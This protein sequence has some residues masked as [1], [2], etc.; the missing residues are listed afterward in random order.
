M[1][2]M[3][4]SHWLTP[5]P[6]PG[7]R[8][9]WVVCDYTEQFTL[10]RDR[11]P[12]VFYGVDHGPSAGSGPGVMARSHCMEPGPGPGQGTGLTQ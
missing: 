7:T 5:G 6:E 12:I 11:D 8:E 2:L 9:K 4:Q 1:A 10:H 3:V